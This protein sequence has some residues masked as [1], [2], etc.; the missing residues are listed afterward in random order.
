MSTEVEAYEVPRKGP[1]PAYSDREWILQDTWTTRQIHVTEPD[2]FSDW[3]FPPQRYA[4][5]SR[6]PF[7]G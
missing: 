5:L 7:R 1:N 6:E 4:G 2:S 3:P